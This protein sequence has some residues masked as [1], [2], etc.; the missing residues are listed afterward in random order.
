MITI[1]VVYARGNLASLLLMRRNN[2]DNNPNFQ[3]YLHFI[4]K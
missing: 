4:N 3:T 2:M 1:V